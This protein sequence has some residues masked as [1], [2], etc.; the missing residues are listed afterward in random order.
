MNNGNSGEIPKEFEFVDYSQIPEHMREGLEGYLEFGWE[1]GG[2]LYCVLTNDLGGA[3]TRADSV[4]RAL[5]LDWIYFCQKE[6]PGR[7]WGSPEAVSA[8]T[9]FRRDHHKR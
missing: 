4:N 9:R 5:L 7:S 6:L 8:W 3:L 1:L 2:F